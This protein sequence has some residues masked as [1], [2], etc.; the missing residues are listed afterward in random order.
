MT[1]PATAAASGTLPDRIHDLASFNQTTS[2]G[3]E[4]AGLYFY[5]QLDCLVDLAYKVSCDFFKRPHLYIT[6]GKLNQ[7]LAQLHARYG[8]DET[9]PSDS[10]RDAIFVPIFGSG[11]ERTLP[12]GVSADPETG[13]F[14]PL[15]DDR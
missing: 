4:V 13:D 9:F 8:A 3:H 12:S 7:T 2:Q 15:R 11:G 5:Q 10:Q 1:H 14:P 6:L